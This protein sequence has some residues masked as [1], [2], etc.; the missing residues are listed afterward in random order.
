MSLQTKQN[1]TAETMGKLA[2]L[3]GVKSSPDRLE[4][5][6]ARYTGFLGEIEKLKKLDISELEPATIF[7][8]GESN[9]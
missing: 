2:E 4:A 5:L 1:I 9:P 7:R 8:A 6:I 3:A